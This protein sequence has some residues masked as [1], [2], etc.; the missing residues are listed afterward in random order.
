[1]VRTAIARIL[2][3]GLPSF[4]PHLTARRLRIADVGCGTGETTLGI[5]RLFPNAEVS[6]FD[7]NDKSIELALKLAEKEQVAN[8]TF[9]RANLLSDIPHDARYDIVTSIGV[10][11]HLEEPR[12][13]FEALRRVI[14]DDGVFLC[15]LYSRAGRWDDVLVK[16]LLDRS[17]D[18]LAFA[19]RARLVSALR[20][21]SRHSMLG[22]IGGLRRRL[23]VGPPVSPLE[24]FKTAMRRTRVTHLS[25]T[26][27][28]PC[29]HLFWFAD[30]QAILASSGWR[31]LGLAPGA[32]LPTSPEEHTSD[33]RQ[34]ALLAELPE[35]V[36]YDVFAHA[37]RA[38][39]FTF[40]AAPQLAND[41]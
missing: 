6:G 32:G 36:R 3:R 4:A 28:N 34:R 30:V 19:E 5:A 1:V 20:L 27:S 25:D 24:L 18:P 22:F 15:F 40:F 8:A 41:G 9:T 21:S 39:G 11:H 33:P 16:D 38:F 10:L 12:V 2:Q 29:E 35:H 17:T 31:F 13:G 37:Y 26:F 14:E 23:R 7:I